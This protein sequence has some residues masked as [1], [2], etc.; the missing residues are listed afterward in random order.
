[1]LPQ[2]GLRRES[3][4][5]LSRLTSRRGND[6]SPVVGATALFDTPNNMSTIRYQW[7]DGDTDRVFEL[8]RVEGTKGHPY[9]FGEGDNVRR[10]EVQDFFIATVTVTQALWAHVMGGEN[11]SCHQGA[12]LPLENVCGTRSRGLV[13]FFIG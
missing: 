11:P 2:V 4:V 13:G 8:V 1:M 3:L 7:N 6:Y 10:I 9:G 5:D 12:D